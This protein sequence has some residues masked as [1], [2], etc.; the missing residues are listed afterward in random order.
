MY[1]LENNAANPITGTWT[2]KGRIALPLDTTSMSASVTRSSPVISQSI[3]T[4]RSF[5]ASRP[6]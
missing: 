6:S 5:I 2:E 1:V 3:H 4:S